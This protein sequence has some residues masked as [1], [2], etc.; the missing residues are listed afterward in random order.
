MLLLTA[1]QACTATASTGGCFWCLLIPAPPAAYAGPLGTRSVLRLWRRRRR[2]GEWPEY[3]GHLGAVGEEPSLRPARP[4]GGQ[5]GPPSSQSAV[6][7]Q[8]EHPAVHPGPP[9]PVPHPP[10]EE[11]RRLR[12]TGPAPGEPPCGAGVELGS[13]PRPQGDPGAQKV[14]LGTRRASMRVSRVQAG[15]LPSPVTVLAP[16][17]LP[18]HPNTSRSVCPLLA[19]RTRTSRIELWGAVCTVRRM[20]SWSPPSPQDCGPCC[21]P[22]VQIRRLRQREVTGVGSAGGRVGI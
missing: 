10:A 11:L 2:S 9:T 3:V 17:S 16:C 6:P 22:T 13:E 21:H 20:S 19:S 8:G 4:A 12:H 7:L 15:L 18:P 1:P 14:R 5:S